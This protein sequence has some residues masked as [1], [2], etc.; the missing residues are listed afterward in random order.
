MADGETW[1]ETYPEAIQKLEVFKDVKDEETLIK[2][3]ED[4]QTYIGQAMR[5]PDEDAGDDDWTAFDE[6]LQS[7]VPHLMR[8]PDLDKEDSVVSTLRILGAPEE[9]DGYVAPEL[10]VDEGMTKNTD[11]VDKF[12]T[13]AHTHNLTQKQFEGVMKDIHQDAVDSERLRIQAFKG[14]R[15]ELQKTWGA[16]HDTNLSAVSVFME[17]TGAPD[18][19]K[20]VAEFGDAATL[21]WLHNL[22]KA[23]S[24]EKAAAAGDH[25]GEKPGA[26]QPSEAQ[27]KISE[28][29]SN[30]K[31]P[32]N[33]IHDPNHKAAKARMRQ[34]YLYADPENA[35]KTTHYGRSA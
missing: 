35:T 3:L 9:I 20:K 31:H 1:V 10:E 22:T 7:K 23:I 33:N 19:L 8:T 13:V 28:I 30:K 34:L 17:K 15:A 32:Y 12:R 29:R 27:A 25:N 6:K 4:Q 14:D 11:I 24:A 2:R 26:M 18:A 16:V 5:V 21:T